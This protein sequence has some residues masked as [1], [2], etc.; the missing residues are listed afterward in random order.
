MA[1]PSHIFIVGSYRSGTSLLR[2]VLNHS[3]DV[4]I[5]GESHFFGSPRTVTNFLKCLLHRPEYVSER[6]ES[7]LLKDRPPGSRQVLA[8]A[9]DLT[10][11]TG[12]KQIVEYIYT[13][14]PN[15]WGWLAEHIPQE[16]F[17]T[18]VLESDRTDRALFDL[19]MECYAR[20]RPIRGEK[21]P[22]HIHAVPTL[23]KWFPR[24][25]VI[26]TF[27]D[28]RA[29]FVS[30]RNKKLRQARPPLRYRAIRQSK[31]AFEVYISI[32]VIT[33]WLR[34]VQLHRQY[35]EQYPQNYYLFKYEDAI[36]DPAFQIKKLCN[37]L[38]IDFTPEMLQHS[39]QNSSV[40][41]PQHMQGFD[42]LAAERW[43]DHLHTYTNRWLVFWSKGH[44]KDFGYTL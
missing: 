42:P 12:A 18:S 23:L 41:Q 3:K 26:H 34:L 31:S 9:G 25:K 40:T 6:Y 38:E 11:E 32:N 35:V 22:D 44:L 36:N 24:A 33:N 7:R 17:L 1:Q 37:W 21:T 28:L 39:Y 14:R 15:F 43:R 5:S 10:T 29:I 2:H 4:A 20:G 30:E 27:R 13:A 8:Q 16:E 19:L